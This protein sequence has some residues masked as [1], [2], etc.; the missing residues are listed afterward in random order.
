M[1]PSSPTLVFDM[2]NVILPFDPM[3]PS[4]VLASKAKLTPDR[5]VALIYRNNLERWFEAGIIDGSRFT[6]EVGRALGLELEPDSF[7]EIWA[8]MFV[9]NEAVSDLIR[10]LKPHHRLILLSNTNVWHWDYAVHHFPIVAEFDDRVVSFEEGVLKPH[11][12]IYRAALEKAGG[13]DE[14]VFIDDIPVNVAGARILGIKGLV[15]TSA[16]QLRQDLRACGCRI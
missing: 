13:Y 3:K 8:D 14:V 10:E 4:A 2:G 9:E 1:T 7:R 12:A 5:V 15:F 16:E 6:R 11:P